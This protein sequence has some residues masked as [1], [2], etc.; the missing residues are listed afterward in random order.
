MKTEIFN[1][2]IAKLN[3]TK[4]DEFKAKQVN[5]LILTIDKLRV[6]MVR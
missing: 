6:D 2:E 3:F 5:E 1:E 4:E